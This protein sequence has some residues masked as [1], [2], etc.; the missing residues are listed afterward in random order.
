MR[1]Q[2]FV[3]SFL[4]YKGYASPVNGVTASQANSYSVERY[5]GHFNPKQASEHALVLEG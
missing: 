3:L 1:S 5:G 4:L 2:L